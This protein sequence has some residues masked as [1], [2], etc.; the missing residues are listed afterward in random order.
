MQTAETPMRLE[1]LPVP[2]SRRQN[3]ETFTRLFQGFVD[4]YG[5]A[6]ARK[7][8]KHLV[9]Q[10]GGYRICIPG[11]GPDP[12]H[13]CSACFRQLWRSTCREFGHASGRAIMNK[14]I[15]ELGGRRVWFPDYRD[16]HIWERNEKISSQYNGENAEELSLRWNLTREWVLR[17][18]RGD[19]D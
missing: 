10:A 4:E 17:I 8:I 16:L 12:L 13:G 9:D 1:V 11:P 2:N 7:I 19:E 3:R 14:I 15:V 6:A 5:E 18:V